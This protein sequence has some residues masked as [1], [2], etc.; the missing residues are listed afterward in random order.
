MYTLGLYTLRGFV[1]PILSVFH[2]L[3]INDPLRYQT[4]VQIASD[5]EKYIP[6]GNDVRMNAYATIFY[7]LYRDGG[8]IGVVLGSLVFGWIMKLVYDSLRVRNDM[9]SY[10]IYFLII[11]QI[12]FSMARFY[13]VF[14]TRAFSYV[15]ALLLFVHPEKEKSEKKE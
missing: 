11:Q 3:G 15:W 9:R 14:P 7:S 13:F 4:V 1:R 8:Y 6:I 2:L 10:V 12:F 5:C